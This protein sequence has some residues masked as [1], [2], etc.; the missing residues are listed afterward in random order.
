MC[1]NECR[2]SKE[3][4]DYI[5]ALGVPTRFV[6]S[7]EV[8]RKKYP[9]KRLRNNSALW[10]PGRIQTMIHS[11]IYKGYRT[12]GLRATLKDYDP[13]P[14]TV[15][16]IVDE[17]LWAKANR[18][19]KSR[20]IISTKQRQGNYLLQGYIYC[21]QC[22]H[23]YCGTYNRLK[24]NT[25]TYYYRC[26]GRDAYGK[27]RKCTLSASINAEWVEH[28]VLDYCAMLLREHTF[29]EETVPPVKDNTVSLERASL[30]RAIK[31]LANEKD[32]ILSLY[33]KNLITLDDLTRQLD[34]IKQ[35]QKSMENRK[36]EL[37][38]PTPQEVINQ[39][40]Q[41]SAEFFKK[42]RQ[43]F[44]KDYDLSNL[45]FQTQREIVKLFIEHIT[46]FTEKYGT[47]SYYQ[48]F[49]VE[50]TD[51]FGNASTVSTAST[52]RLKIQED[53]AGNAIHTV[54]G[55]LRSLRLERGYTQKQ[56][57]EATGLTLATVNAF[58]NHRRP[59]SNAAFQHD[60]LTRLAK[61]YSIPYEA[62]S[63]YNVTEIASDERTLFTQVRDVKGLTSDELCSEMGISRPTFRKYLKGKGS[64]A[65][66]LK[67]RTYLASARKWLENLMQSR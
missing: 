56:V 37:E 3:I 6:F 38:R 33:R 39:N 54:G 21:G 40:R 9:G 12:Y 66:R 50:I 20:V 41:T 44:P 55:K 47:D 5:N 61:F 30:D 32:S 34:K 49:R 51:K 16:A 24:G 8:Q 15:P 17:K 14:Q 13:I 25:A 62:L 11:T 18:S 2:T 19:L 45:S 29:M 35:E 42:F 7:E 26:N 57:S 22:G 23:T 48:S 27:G 28:M 46:V 64:E 36:Q 53:K 4:A 1:G 43:N 31:N 65:S 63:I 10:S 52:L 59:S 58:E 67:I 60:S